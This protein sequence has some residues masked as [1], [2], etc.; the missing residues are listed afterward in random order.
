MLRTC[1]SPKCARARNI[2][3]CVCTRVCA[4]NNAVACSALRLKTT[5]FQEHGARGPYKRAGCIVFEMDPR[6]IL[7]PAEC[8]GLAAEAAAATSVSL[9]F[10]DDWQAP[11]DLASKRYPPRDNSRR[12]TSKFSA[13]TFYENRRRRRARELRDPPPAPPPPPADFSFSNL[14]ESF[15]HRR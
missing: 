5:I 6:G 10:D 15:F 8:V 11:R 7:D 12:P 2:Y 3:I 14:I 1:E 13:G 4:G 9:G